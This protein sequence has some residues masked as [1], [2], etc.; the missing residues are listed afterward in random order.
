MKIAYTQRATSSIGGSLG[1]PSI[2]NDRRVGVRVATLPKTRDRTVAFYEVVVADSAE[3]RRVEQFHWSE[4]LAGLARTSLAGRTVE[5]EKTLV[6]NVVT[7]ED[8]DH[9]LLHRAKDAGE[10]LAVMNWNTGEWRELEDRAV[11]GYL[12][13]SAV[14]FLPFGNIIGIIRGS[15]SAPTHK[16]VERWLNEL[17]PFTGTSLVVRALMSQS[18]VERLRTA[19]GA[20]RVEIRIGSHKLSALQDRRG[21]LARVLRM[22]GEEYG[23]IDV[24]VIISVPRGKARTEDRRALLQDLQELEDVMPNAAARAEAKLVYAEQHGPEHRQLAEFV[25][26][27]IT[28]KRRVAVVDDRGEVIRILSAVR[29]ILDVAAEHADELREAADVD[30]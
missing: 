21:R 23:D 16:D 7:Y 4:F 20:S 19:D 3:H 5:I 11:E 8:E 22:A 18:E 27:H 28:A 10:W 24:T 9:L 6:G 14:C 17:K 15:N 1:G 29:V 30:S 12:E 26:H 25:E 2:A 13:T